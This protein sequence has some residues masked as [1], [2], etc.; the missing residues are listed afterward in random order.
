MRTHPSRS[1]QYVV[2]SHPCTTHTPPLLGFRVLPLQTSSSK[3]RLWDHTLLVGS[4]DDGDYDHG[5]DDDHHH[6][7]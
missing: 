1:P 2:R 5:N 3:G 6:H 4:I 7:P